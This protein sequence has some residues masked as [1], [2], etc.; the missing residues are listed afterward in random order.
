MGSDFLGFFDKFR[1]RKKQEQQKKFNPETQQFIDNTINFQEKKDTM[2]EP[3]PIEQE[4]EFEKVEPVEEVEEE[5]EEKFE[6]MNMFKEK[7]YQNR[8]KETARAYFSAFSNAIDKTGQRS[9]VETGKIDTALILD[10]A[11]KNLKNRN[12]VSKLKNALKIINPSIFRDEIEELTVIHD[13]KKKKRRK[14][15][16]QFELNTT[17][18]RINNIKNKKMKLAFRFGFVSGARASELQN[19]TKD[20]LILSKGKIAVKLKGKGQKY[21]EVITLNDKYVY[22][23]L[24]KYLKDLNGTDRLFYSA[25]YMQEIA[26][27]NKFHIHQLRRAYAQV[28]YYKFDASIEHLQTLLG[29]SHRTTTYL[30]YIN[31][32]C[33]LTGTKWDIV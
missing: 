27:K 7:L 25:D 22:T 1:F 29:H 21:R 28:C 13:K 26:R 23:E 24:E 16:K 14:R 8:T 3:D 19:V 33:N 15:H 4:E 31:Y 32:P 2:R 20:D 10:Y 18:R 5:V 6:Y 17:M 9:F 12:E 11:K 30:K